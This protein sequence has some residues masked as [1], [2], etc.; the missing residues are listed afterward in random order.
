MVDAHDSGSCGEIL[1]GSNPFP[2]IFC[3]C[4][5]ADGMLWG[6]KLNS[7]KVKWL[8]RDMFSQYW[9]NFTCTYFITHFNLLTSKIHSI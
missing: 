4:A 3:L 7:L 2:D 8:N 6:E 9:H 1:E 5:F